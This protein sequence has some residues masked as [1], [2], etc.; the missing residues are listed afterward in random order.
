MLTIAADPNH[1]F[2]ANFLHRHLI[3]LT[4][5][6][7]DSVWS[8]YLSKQYERR[9]A[10]DRL[11]EWAWESRKEHISDESIELCAVALSW[12][13]TTSHR[14]VRDRATKAL[15]SMLHSRAYILSKVIERFLEVNDLYVLERLYAVAYGVAMISGDTEAI[16]NLAGRVY[17]WVFANG[18]PIPHILLRDYARGVIEIANYKRTLPSEVNLKL[19]RPPYQT[20]WLVI[21]DLEELKSLGISVDIKDDRQFA[22]SAIRESVMGFGDFARY[23]IGTNSNHFEWSCCRLGELNSKQIHALRKQKVNEFEKSLTSKQ[24][25][26]WGRY[27]NI[28][29]IVTLAKNLDAQQRQEY[30]HEELTDLEL[31]K[32]LEVTEERFLH[33]IGNRGKIYLRSSSYLI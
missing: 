1:P 30:L 15:V 19:V 32:W 6:D 20:T 8:I 4:M 2:N 29:S 9:E 17:N 11:I 18:K 21:P 14:Y 12:F 25:K 33:L 26:S 3:K 10:S 7:R 27:K 31:D 16:G 24:K 22:L 5:P 13:L 23:I 28:R